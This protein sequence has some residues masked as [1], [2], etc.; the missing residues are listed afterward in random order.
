MAD[1]T[2]PLCNTT[3]SYG[4]RVC[5]GCQAT[6]IYGATEN[7]TKTLGPIVGVGLFAGIVYLFGWPGGL[8][9]A[10]LFIGCIVAAAIA[11]SALLRNK[12]SFHRVMLR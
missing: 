4:V 6:V 11:V 7:D 10:G 12:I 8:K 5:V 9:T 2:C 3:S 1:I